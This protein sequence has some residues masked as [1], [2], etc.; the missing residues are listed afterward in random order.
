MPWLDPAKVQVG[1]LRVAFYPTNG[2]PDTAPET[3]A[4]VKQAAKW[5]ADAGAQVTE[6]LP[7]ELLDELGSIRR[8]LTQGD[9]WAFL[10]RAGDRAG[11]KILSASIT[12]RMDKAK[13][14]TADRYTELLEMQDRNR[15]RMLQWF[16]K[17][18]LILCPTTDTPAPVID[19]GIQDA[20]PKPGAG[21]VGAFNTTGWP[22]TVVR[23]GG[24]KE[25]LPI[26]V[27]VVAHP[28]RE[29]VSLAA[30][31]YLES[32]SGGWKKPPL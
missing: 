26:G 5:L 32:R 1:K 6:D 30:A 16:Q 4:A 3:Q 7:K 13:P 29:D 8:E 22:V 12:D 10:K 21:Y 31:Q 18:D 15:S 20:P 17:Y 25:G 11:S 23:C 24:T 2:L 9:S 27:Q 28:W 19:Q 14:V